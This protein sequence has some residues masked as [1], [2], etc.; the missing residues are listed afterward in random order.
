VAEKVTAKLPDG[1][2]F[3]SVYQGSG[4]PPADA[5]GVL[6]KSDQGWYLFRVHAGEQ[7]P[8]PADAKQVYITAAL[9][10][11]P[12]DDEKQALQLVDLKAKG[13]AQAHKSN[14]VEVL[15]AIQGKLEVHSGTFTPKQLGS[16]EGAFVLDNTPLQAWALGDTPATFLDFHLLPS[17]RPLSQDLANSP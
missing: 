2:L 7:S 10:S 4:T 11:L 14:G 8:A 15:L 1:T 6:Y 3:I 13:R 16:G 9:P 12:P 17:V 5:E